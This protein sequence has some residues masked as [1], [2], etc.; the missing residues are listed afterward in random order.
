MGISMV[1]GLPES[2]PPFVGDRFGQTP[3]GNQHS[4]GESKGEKGN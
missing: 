3:S 2:G 1:E 4:L